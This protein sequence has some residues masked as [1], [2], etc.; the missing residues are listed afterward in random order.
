M[1]NFTPAAPKWPAATSTTVALNS[2]PAKGTATSTAKASTASGAK[3]G[4][5]VA[6]TPVTL[7]A[8]GVLTK[9]LLPPTKAARTAL[10]RDTST[11]AP[12]AVSVRV[13][14]H[15]TAVKAGVKG[16]AVALSAQR[17]TR[18]PVA[19]SRASVAVDYSAIA[20][21]YGGDYAS[22][23]QLVQLPPCSLT[24]PQVPSCQ[25]ETP[26]AASTNDVADHKLVADVALPAVS[27]TSDGTVVFAATPAPS[28]GAGSYSATSLAP[29][30]KWG[31]SG[32][33]GAFTYDYPIT[34]PPSVGGDAPSVSLDYN[35]A[36]VDGRT[37]ATNNQASWIGD[38]WDYNPG[39]IERSYRPCAD[40]ETDTNGPL[41]NDFD[42]C[43]AGD[44]AT[45]SLGGHSG[46]LVP[47]GTNNVWRLSDD[48][49]TTV[50][51][52]SGASNGLN[53]GTYWDVTTN[54]GTQYFFGADH[55]PTSVAGSGWTNTDTST[56]SAWGVPVYGNDSGEPCN[57]STFANSSCTQGWRWNLDFVVDPDQNITTYSYKAETNYYGRGASHT[58]TSYTRGGYLATI[59]Y[60]QNVT[61]YKAKANPAAEV[62]FGVKQ[63]CDNAPAGGDCSAP[64]TS[65]SSHWPD[66]PF[67]QNCASTGTCTNYA[68]TFWSTMRLDTIT[69]KV[70]DES[71]T[72]PTWSNVD[73]YQLKQTYPAV[74][75]DGAKP[76]MWLAS[77]TRTG[78]DTR[79][80]DTTSPHT[81]PALTLTGQATLPNRVDGLE[82]P[83]DISPLY[84]YRL[85][86][87]TT[88]TG[89]TITVTYRQDTC[90]RTSPPSE[91]ADTSL[92]YPVR[93]TPPGYAAP[94]LDWFYI[95]P[96]AEVDQGDNKT[97]AS[98]PQVTT[99]TYSSPAWHR[100]DSELTTG[101]YRTYGD[102]RGF[103]H[104]TTRTGKSPDPITK[105][106]TD[107]LQGMGGTVTDLA[108][109][110]VTD[111][112]ALGG[113]AYQ[114]TTYDKDGG[115]P[116]AEAVNHPWL[117][118]ATATHT[119]GGTLPDLTA[120]L[121][122]TDKT[123]TRQL[124]ADGTWRT[125]ETTTT[126]DS[127]TGLPTQVDDKGE[128]DSSGNPVTGTTTPEKCV[129]TQYAS[130]TARNM[131]A[132]ADQ[133]ITEAG[134]CVT[135]PDAHTLSATRTWYDTATPGGT[136]GAISG[137]GNPTATQQ[138]KTASGSTIT[139]TQPAT[140]TY[141]TYGRP[142]GTVDPL[143]RTTGTSYGTTTT[144][145]KYLPVTVV[146]TNA[147]GWKTTTTMDPGRQLPLTTTDY[148]G[149]LT[150]Q[151]YDELGRLTQ[152]WLPDHTKADNP[153]TPNSKY[154]YT[155]SATAP[156]V[157]ETQGLLDGGNY[158]VDYKIYDSMLQTRQEQSS[159]K[160][161]GTGRLITDT[162]YDS[163]GWTTSTDAAF[164]N[165]DSNPTSTLVTPLPAQ[166]PSNTRTT[167]DG[168]GRTTDSALYSLGTLQWHT[169]TGYPGADQATV[170]PPA[171]GTATA[172]LTDVRGQTTELRQFHST[173]PSGAYDKTDYTF[174][175]AGQALTD[176]GPLDSAT[177]PTSTAAK[178]VTWTKSYDL[179]GD[180]VQQTDPDTGTST[181]TYDDDQEVTQ[182]SDARPNKAGEI[183]TAYDNLGRVTS[184][185]GWNTSGQ[186]TPLTT[187]TYDDLLK[188]QPTGV[189]TYENGK[190]SYKTTVSGYTTAYQPTGS[191]ITI[192]AG[193]YGN[194]SAITYTTADTYTEVQ[195]LPDTAKISTTGTGSLIP[196]ET[197]YYAYN[198]IGLPR[199]VG[200]T[201]AYTSWID[202]SPLGQVERTTQGIKPQQVVTTDNWDQAT[203]HL[204]SY[205][206][207]KEDADAAVDSVSYTYNAAGQITSTSDVQ[208]GGSTAQTDT[209]CYTYDYLARLT[210][211]WTDTGGTHTAASPTVNGIGG[212]NNTTP[213]ATNLGGP[214]PY[215]QSYTYD[216][217]GNRTSKTIHDTAGD[218]SQDATTT[219]TYD[220]TDH[221]H[222]VH[223]ATTGATTQTYTYDEDGN[224]TAIATT[225]AGQDQTSQDQ[226]LTWNTQGNLATLTAGPTGNPTHSTSYHYDA[227][228]NLTARTDDGTTTIYL[229]TDELTLNSTGTITAANRS[230]GVAGAPTTIRT[231]TAGTSGTKVDY[232]LPDPQGTSTTDITA[233][234][235][236]VT[237]RAYTPFGETR[238]P[239]PGTW[240]GD[241][242]YIGGTTDPTT[243]LTNL[244]ARE[245]NPNLGR[246][247]NP[248]PL[249]ATT[250]PQQWNGYAYADNTPV[251][252]ADPSGKMLKDD[253]FGYG[254]GNAKVMS[255]WY[256]DEGYAD[257]K[258]KPTP[259]FRYMQEYHYW[260]T[261]Y[262]TTPFGTPKPDPRSNYRQADRA[263]TDAHR[264]LI[265]LVKN[266]DL[267][268]G[269]KDPGIGLKAARWL[270]GHTVTTAGG[271]VLFVC[272]SVTVQDRKVEATYGLQVAVPFTKG[273]DSPGSTLED[274]KKLTTSVAGFGASVGLNSKIPSQQNVYSETACA[275]D[276]FGGCMMGAP[277]SG[278]NFGATVGAGEGFT[279][280]ASHTTTWT[281]PSWAPPVIPVPVLITGP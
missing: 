273:S 94:I 262:L 243:S 79:G 176:I 18:A 276:G 38:G 37:S 85:S 143:G 71:L 224:P 162:A 68:P 222:A 93:W 279:A 42:D 122:G 196:D 105:S 277:G 100:D 130:D 28:G 186:Q 148:N 39:F 258:G 193:A 158:S 141:D 104:V 252:S 50:K 155:V 204:L 24:T 271:C 4:V 116:Q 146:A 261:A 29:S 15:A 17:A 205:S 156:N 181:S 217:T 150:T 256:K 225:Q 236:T 115:T 270:G 151:T 120:H 110:T 180:V 44:N 241:K 260:Y 190:T 154:S 206:N 211:A 114:T 281:L 63:R 127:T 36:S 76:A 118:A 230:Y 201:D 161:G 86:S 56:N 33:T 239:Q 253:V 101:K 137:A 32:N 275:Y 278:G 280:S 274:L 92:C 240:P 103:A 212:C 147:K 59:A 251:D 264:D 266:I 203:G 159:P 178:A 216:L 269:P 129:S 232:Q 11:S 67:D 219:E 214:A 172:A 81:T 187:R 246:F 163:H 106:V 5:R 174:D 75:G 98:T 126:Y 131:T 74:A 99:Y 83:Q 23:L 171:G 97:T 166:V 169:T 195:D 134:P 267:N 255:N 82:E 22:R 202:Y 121:S 183:D 210:A 200:G 43:W 52:L 229:G 21:A 238:T 248:D 207:N 254:Y 27:D 272:G 177:S 227:D 25:T 91:S 95:Y 198:G 144:T 7:A 62:V 102:F 2:T 218:T 90:S 249:R 58:L 57:A 88:E 112:N 12:E 78:A 9:N 242:G 185:S 31:E 124:K 209:Q 35:S 8:G 55:L 47:T 244:G 140:T 168:Q 265:H 73:T 247:L 66:T 87:L 182:A 133:V 191:T 60:G 221:T 65:T 19:A 268:V 64:T 160:D 119:R 138:A 194:T 13:V 173:T 188:G 223:T 45:L 234:T 228:G 53:G 6:K 10:S 149:R 34:V 237:R 152:V 69:T 3:A 80:G 26:V 125:A 263:A 14:G 233:D 41:K 89:E 164:Y 77:V 107:Y 257:K 208:D 96:V 226:T 189:T 231:A 179:L 70:W 54:D 250:D 46:D 117:S 113:F 235:L 245:Y 1:K 109:D 259:K 197:L 165:S 132:F 49:G 136:L 213:H 72:T 30:G 135:T 192:P 16:I 61:D 51:E 111:D 48:D 20:D 123:D 215:W 40:D 108:G 199:G 157:V 128:V 84:R 153:T 220:T 175:A 139:W 167:F 145:Q 170:T 184:T 142:T